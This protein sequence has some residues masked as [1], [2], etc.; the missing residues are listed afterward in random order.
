MTLAT[1]ANGG[2]R[3]IPLLQTYDRYGRLR[4]AAGALVIHHGGYYARSTWAFF[5]VDNRDLFEDQASPAA[6]VL[7]DAASFIARRVS[8]RGIG[9]DRRMY[10]PGETVNAAVLVDNRGKDANDVAILWT[11]RPHGVKEDAARVER[12]TTVAANQIERVA[13]EFGELSPRHD[14]YEIQAEMWIDGTPVDV[15]TTGFVVDRPELLSSGP[16]LRFEDNYFTLDGRPMF[17]FG[18]DTYSYTYKSPHENPLTWAAE[19]SAS[20]DF[21]FNLYEDLQYSPPGYTMSEADRRD[22]RAMA[23]LTQTHGLVFMPGM[24]IGRNVAIGDELLARQS[25]L[26]AEYARLLGDV[27]GLLYYI[28]G[29]YR[30]ELGEHPKDVR[31]LWNRW[32]TERYGST[33][34]LRDAWGEE[35]VTAELGELDYWPPDTGR[36][37][38]PAAVD[39][40]RFQNWLTRRWNA[41]HVKALREIDP[42]HPITSEYYMFC[43]GGMDLRQTI[44]GQDVSNIGFFDKPVDDILNL[45]LK[46]GFNDLRVRGKGVSLGEYGAK[47]HPAWTPENG[48]FGYHLV[49]TLDQRR[50]LFMAVAH[51]GLGMGASKIQNWCLRDAQQWIFPWGV[52]YPHELIPKDCAYV[53]RNQSIV[54]RHFSPRYEP[55]R[56]SVCLPN[57]MRLGNVEAA[58]RTVADSALSTVL[59]LHQRFNVI[60]D[61]HFNALSPRCRVMIYPAPFC[62]EN[63]AYE[64]LKEWVNEGGMLLITGDFSYD[65]HRRRTGLNRLTELAAVTHVEDLYPNTSRPASPTAQC[66]FKN[67]ILPAGLTPCLRIEPAGAEVL[68]ASE[69]DNPVLARNRAGKGWVWY[70]TDPTEVC[71][72][73]QAAA[74]RRQVYAAFLD[75]AGC[76]PTSVTPTEDWLHVMEQPTAKGRIHVVSNRRMMDGHADVEIETQAGKVAL[77]VRNAY[78]ALAAVTEDGQVVS[79]S[80][81]GVAGVVGEPIMSGAG[82]RAMIS[83]DGQD[84]RS[85]RAILT[86]PFDTG[87]LELPARDAELTAVVGEFQDGEWTELERLQID[88][89]RPIIDIDADRATGLILL[90]EPSA[91]QRWVKHLNRAMQR[92]QELAGY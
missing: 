37:D 21:G 34:R 61:H 67:G 53:H 71:T 89:S 62:V 58:G 57:N 70:F 1:P 82:L 87:R 44:D 77:R 54:W 16:Q 32:L 75:A 86:A 46:I 38:D 55:T 3:R 39:R 36:W 25:G 45:P 20:R 50:Q 41:A 66:R 60:D 2:A 59:S 13:A 69:D 4:G 27:P 23:Q 56:L 22:F 28:N 91:E 35:K 73:A 64:R 52:F 42:H 30:M 18:S 10:R 85:S 7:R 9:T 63:D 81:D 78:P 14:L 76:K 29:D 43:W 24:L 83:L 33:D 47:T 26:C 68:G 88:A 80:A 11:F 48:A 17:L 8:L 19:H 74:A 72:D 84:L 49:H 51:V 90:C 92:P 65:G 5:G 15:M 12:A 6:G 79:V 31:A 40:L